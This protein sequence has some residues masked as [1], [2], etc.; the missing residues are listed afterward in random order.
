MR[1]K[2][3]FLAAVLICLLAFAGCGKDYTT[4]FSEVNQLEGVTLELKEGTLKSTSGTFL[5]T[6]G[7][8]GE[9][10]YRLLYHLEEKKDGV[11]QEFPGTAG[12]TWGE[13]TAAVAAG[14][15][16]EIPINWKTLCGGIG[17]G[18]YRIIL[19]VNDMPVAA[20]FTQE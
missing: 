7:S 13:D 19:L 12:A 14:E 3:S 16:E 8:D 10:S 2:C 5:L 18:E 9:V 11:W 4:Q 20:E 6:N 17:K 1:K 15:T